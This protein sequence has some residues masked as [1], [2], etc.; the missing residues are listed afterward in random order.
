MKKFFNLRWLSIVRRV[1]YWVV[2]VVILYVVFSRIDF[3]A[4]KTAVGK[5]RKDFFLLGLL[6]APFFLLAGA[7]RWYTLL[8]QYHGRAVGA[9]F[10]LKHYW[11]GYSL[12]VF[13][14]ASIGWDLYRIAVSARKFGRLVSNTMII[15]T[16]KLMALV[17]CT[18]LIILV[19]PQLPVASSSEAGKVLRLAYILFLGAI[20]L[21]AGLN[22]ALRNRMLLGFLDRMETYLTKSIKRALAKFNLADGFGDSRIHLKEMIKPLTSPGKLLP[23]ILL[24][25]MIQ[26]ISASRA[27]VFFYSLGYH[28]PLAV[29]FFVAP[30][31]F[32]IFLLPISF[33]SLG[34][35][36]GA[37]ILLYGLFGVPAEIALLVSFFNLSCMLI[38]HLIGGL[39]ILYSNIKG[40]STSKTIQEN[41]V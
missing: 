31:L 37:H 11:I 15:I 3:E 16:E 8:R 25:F 1:I 24:S 17:T 27:Q 13:A 23:V 12:G 2:P 41:N 33:G 7:I 20:V 14:P 35:R 10:A 5:T 18:L 34:I 4:L 39:L 28:I 32:F 40:E 26:F 30:V 21:L 38:N 9:G 22:L 29:N 6:H 19:Y 36:E